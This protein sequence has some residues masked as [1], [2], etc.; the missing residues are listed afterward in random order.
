MATLL[1]ASPTRLAVPV[2]G[3]LQYFLVVEKQVVLEV[4][5]AANLA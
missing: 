4:D 5:Q 2:S 1:Y 3:A